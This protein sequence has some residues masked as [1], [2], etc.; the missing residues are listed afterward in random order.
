MLGFAPISALPISGL[1]AAGAIANFVLCEGTDVWAAVADG[2]ITYG[3]DNRVF[4]DILTGY[5]NTIK[6]DL[7]N[8]RLVKILAN[9][10]VIPL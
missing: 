7:T 10:V 1:P 9:L 4:V 6:Y 3:G 8:D 2:K 5:D